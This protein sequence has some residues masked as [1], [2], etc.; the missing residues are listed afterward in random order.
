MEV[1]T[2]NFTKIRGNTNALIDIVNMPQVVPTL[3]FNDL[4]IEENQFDQHDF[5]F[6][7]SLSKVDVVVFNTLRFINNSN[8]PSALILYRVYL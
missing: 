3:I 1:T 4:T 5:R 2:L 7:L 8:R 6:F